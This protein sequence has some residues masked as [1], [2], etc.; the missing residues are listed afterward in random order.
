MFIDQNN[1]ERFILYYTLIFKTCLF[2]KLLIL[3]IS[4]LYFSKGVK[5]HFKYL[6]WYFIH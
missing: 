6:N 1:Y 5:R 2:I 4:N 3:S